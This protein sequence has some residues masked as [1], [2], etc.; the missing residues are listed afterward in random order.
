MKASNLF[1]SVGDKVT[2][3]GESGRG[4]ITAVTQ[5]GIVTIASA[6]GFATWTKRAGEYE[7][8]TEEEYRELARGNR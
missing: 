4:S 8:L 6:D 7:L 2:L 5:N 1:P 3:V